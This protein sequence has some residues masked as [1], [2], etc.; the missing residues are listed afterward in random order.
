MD[1]AFKEKVIEIYM[2]FGSVVISTSDENIVK[3]K[4][5]PSTF[6]AKQEATAL[7][8]P[9]KK[10]ENIKI[11]KVTGDSHHTSSSGLTLSSNSSQLL[12]IDSFSKKDPSEFVLGRLVAVDL[13]PIYK[14]S[15]SIHIQ[16]RS[17]AQVLKFQ[18]QGKL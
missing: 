17:A 7:L 18:V 14:L 4:Y 5:C 1:G 3:C 6:K 16:K 12:I 15:Q 8:Y 9:L 2:K 13:N 11:K 10:V